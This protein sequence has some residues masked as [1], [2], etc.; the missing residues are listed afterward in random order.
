MKVP[1]PWT[2]T[3]CRRR[4]AEPL[5]PSPICPAALSPQQYMAPTVLIPQVCKTPADRR[6]HMICEV[7]GPL[8]VAYSIGVLVTA[9]VLVGVSVG[10]LVDIGA[11][12]D[13][14]PGVDVA[15]WSGV[16]VT[17]G[18]LVEVSVLVEVAVFVTVLVG[19]E[20]MVAHVP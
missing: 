14:G 16:L 1:F 4:F 7:E 6:D 3:G 13:E 9:G 15:V 11:L 2:A 18:V 17:V 8:V 19:V 5:V 12:V 20:V 10:V